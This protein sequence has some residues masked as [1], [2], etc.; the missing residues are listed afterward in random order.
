MQEKWMQTGQEQFY[1]NTNTSSKVKKVMYESKINIKKNKQWGEN[2]VSSRSSRV[3]SQQFSS[4][5]TQRDVFL[6]R[7][8]WNVTTI[9][10]LA[11]VPSRF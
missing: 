5:A 9:G 7:R 10:V 2:D 1:E 3:G 4:V 11:N 8:W 6:W